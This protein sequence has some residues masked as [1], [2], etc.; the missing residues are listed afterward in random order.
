L[1][2]LVAL[3]IAGGTLL[4]NTIFGGGHAANTLQTAHA[5]NSAPP[6]FTTQQLS[7]MQSANTQMTYQ[8]LARLYV[9][10]MPLDQELGQL[11]IAQTS[12]STYDADAQYMIKS[13][14][15]GGLILYKSA[16]QNA[17][18]SKQ[19]LSAMQ[20]DS[21]TPLFLG[22]DEE[23]WNVDRLGNIFPQFNQQPPALG[24]KTNYAYSA[25]EMEEMGDPNFDHTVGQH[26]AQDM[27]SLGLNVNFA[28]D[29]DVSIN[30]G[31]IDWDYRDFGSTSSDVI[32]YAGPYLEGLQQGGVIGTL[33][34]FVGLGSVPRGTNNDPHYTLPTANITQSQLY[35]TYLVPFKHFIQTSNTMEQPG[36][37]MPT[38]VMVPA[39]DSKYPVEFSH[40]FI[41]DILRNQLG[42]NGVIVT[43]S[44]TMG[45]VRINGVQMTEAQ[46][47]LMALQAGDDML[48]DID[49][50][51]QVASVISTLKAAIQNGTLSKQRVDD[52]ATHVITLKMQRGL[53]PT[54]LSKN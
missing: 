52:A 13:Q 5:G 31:Y 21:A 16:F 28:P 25:N 53:L 41:T 27:R 8:Q 50:S 49:G 17:T 1:L 6:A 15:I 18:Q 11:I 38:D 36:F 40:T 34:H 48:L 43:D 32:K 42:Y 30:Q 10:R 44:L 23:G 22:I 7:A 2:V 26:V 39:V 14:H 47:S 20:Q 45:G 54:V 33:K 12:D 3:I 24:D 35:S 4:G 51:Q 9:S 19:E 46:A 29:V 37:I